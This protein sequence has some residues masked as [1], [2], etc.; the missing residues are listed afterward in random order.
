MAGEVTK[1]VSGFRSVVQDL[2]VPELKSIRV[3][4]KHH[5]EEFAKIDKRF[6]AIDKRFEAIDKRFEAMDRRFETL[7]R[8]M[9][10]RFEAMNSRF[11]LMVKELSETKVTQ[12]EILVK[13]DVKEEVT[14]T[15]A[16]TS[17]LERRLD[18][19]L[20]IFKSAGLKLVPEG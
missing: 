12:K 17:E 9:N 13:L 15:S 6:E 2:L 11:E 10:T 8:E 5:S 19:L 7:Q 16:K 14:A 20:A 3:E 4:L 18:D 1:M